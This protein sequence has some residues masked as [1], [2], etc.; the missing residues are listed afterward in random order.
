M[1]N[2]TKRAGFL[3]RFLNT[4]EVVG[5]RLPDPAVLFLVL[6]ASGNGLCAFFARAYIYIYIYIYTRVP[7]CIMHE[8]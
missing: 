6:M 3:D 5:N 2:D 7:S 1:V 8:R 4:I